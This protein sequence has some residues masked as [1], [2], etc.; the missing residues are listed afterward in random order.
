[1]TFQ[2]LFPETL[3]TLRLCQNR[4]LISRQHFQMHLL[5]KFQ[6]QFPKIWFIRVQSTKNQHCFDNGLVPKRHDYQSTGFNELNLCH[7][8]SYMKQTPLFFKLL[9]YMFNCFFFTKFKFQNPGDDIYMGQVTKLWLSCYLV[10]L[11]IDSM[12]SIDS[13]TR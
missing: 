2:I 13:K 8:T 3:N 5:L 7:T 12:L 9:S 1:M 11:S 6:L 10:L 4:P